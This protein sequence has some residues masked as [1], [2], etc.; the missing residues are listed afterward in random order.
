MKKKVSYTLHD[1]SDDRM[2]ASRL[3]S[4]DWEELY[5]MDKKIKD[6]IREY[7]FAIREKLG[8][9]AYAL[10][11]EDLRRHMEDVSYEVFE[12]TCLTYLRN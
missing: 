6:M 8:K 1:L 7:E 5:D 12:S 2:A 4:S 10:N 9:G 11:L 3:T